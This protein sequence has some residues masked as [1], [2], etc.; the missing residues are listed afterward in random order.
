MKKFSEFKT[1]A[2]IG[3]H[4]TLGVGKTLSK[5]AE[6]LSPSIK[7][8]L[9]EEE[10]SKF[11][12]IDSSQWNTKIKTIEYIGNH[13]D[14]A[15]VLGGDGTLLSV[16][17]TLAPFKVPLIGINFGRLG[18]ITDIAVTEIEKVI[19]EMLN[20]DYK[21]DERLLLSAH[22]ERNKKNIHQTIA[23]NDVVV[24]RSGVSGMV[25]LSVEVDQCFM[26]TMRSDGLIVSTTTGSTAYALAV[27]GP[28]LQP[29]LNGI[30]LAPIAP[31]TLSNR[32]IVLNADVEIRMQII[33]GREVNVNFDMQSFTA[34]KTSD[35]IV[36]KQSIHKAILLHPKNWS[37]F[38]ILREKLKW[39][40]G[41]AHISNKTDIN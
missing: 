29:Q 38:K 25:D 7:E 37:Y 24:N 10:T 3:K 2:L 31:H 4:N 14:V 12:Q 11:C 33:G 26:Y 8:I 17:R 39:L 18:F 36:V 41:D 34:L 22:I 30:L 20:G 9:L 13:A 40:G 15:I 16:A 5:I 35:T 27:Q 32:P 19:P 6:I 28:I 23:L 21:R 1:I